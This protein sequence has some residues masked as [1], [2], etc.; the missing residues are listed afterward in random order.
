[1]T[2]K[3]FNFVGG[4][5]YDGNKPI[6]HVEDIKFR[7]DY[8]DI[9]N[10]LHEENEQLKKTNQELFDNLTEC[11]SYKSLKNGEISI[12]ERENEQFHNIANDYNI[13]FDKLCETFEQCLD[14]NEQ[15]KL[16]INMLKTTIA[17]NEAH[18]K[19]LTQ[20]SEWRTS[21]YD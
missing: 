4:Y 3:R 2:E 14:E 16:E 8:E 6:G 11:M 1:M 17:R 21:A 18:I 7:Q 15:L 9:V 5:L 12:L 19:R 10:V 20:T 13:S